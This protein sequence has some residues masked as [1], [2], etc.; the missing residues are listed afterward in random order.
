[1]LSD[2]F[3]GNIDQCCS[4]RD[5]PVGATTVILELLPSAQIDERPDRHVPNSSMPFKDISDLACC[6]HATYHHTTTT[7]RALATHVHP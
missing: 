2:A 4:A 6:M 1:M 3:A 7:T 5:Y